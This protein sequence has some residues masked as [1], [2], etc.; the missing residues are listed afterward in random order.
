MPWEG[1]DG[2]R[3]FPDGFC[4][5]PLWFQCTAQNLFLGLATQR[6]N[7]D[8]MLQAP[9]ARGGVQDPLATFQNS[10]QNNPKQH[11]TSGSQFFTLCLS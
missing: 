10:T 9:G 4:S 11:P 1:H 3:G 6:S 5:T 2:R 7:S 8:S